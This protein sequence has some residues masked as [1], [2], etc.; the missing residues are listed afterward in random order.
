M[1]FFFLPELTVNNLYYTYAL[2]VVELVSYSEMKMYLLSN[3]DTN[4]FFMYFFLE[5]SKEIPMCTTLNFQRYKW[6]NCHL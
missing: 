6:Q 5:S 1:F 3:Q 4:T 2:I